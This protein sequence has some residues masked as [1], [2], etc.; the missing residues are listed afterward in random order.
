MPVWL[1][2]LIPAVVLAAVVGVIWA[3]SNSESDDDSASTESTGGTESTVV[4]DTDLDRV[5]RGLILLGGLRE[6]TTTTEAPAEET[7]P[8]T[9]PEETTPEETTPEEKTPE[10][11]APDTPAATDAPTTTDASATTGAP[12]TTEAP[13]TTDAPESTDAPET[14]TSPPS[15]FP[16]VDAFVDQWNEAAADTNVPTINADQAEEL[17]GDYAGYYLITLSPTNGDSLPPQVGLLG[18]VT[19]PGSGQLNE[20][21]L[22]WIPGVDEAS[23]DFYWESF[24]VLTQAMSP[25]SD[26]TA[27]LEAEL[28]REPAVPPFTAD[29]DASGSGFDYSAF[30]QPY[31]DPDDGE[32]EVSAISVTEG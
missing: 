16:T 1:Q 8:D 18:T 22:V 6:R 26:D 25:G 23:S 2:I 13:G 28:G 10:E 31:E 20:V 19:S 9:T 29:A 11:T 4:D 3:L 27:R 30:T 24:G 7:L 17:T 15:E 14:T 12:A 32:V 21:L 5:L